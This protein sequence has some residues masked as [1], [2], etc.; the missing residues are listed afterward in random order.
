MVSM[1]C[2]HHMNPLF[3]ALEFPELVRA[4]IDKRG[5]M[6]MICTEEEGKDYI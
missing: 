2:T 4:D 3:L 6:S 5:E 1:S